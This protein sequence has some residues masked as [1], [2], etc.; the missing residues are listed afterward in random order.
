M[1][2]DLAKA[3]NAAIDAMRQTR[4]L[5]GIPDTHLLASAEKRLADAMDQAE[6]Q[7]IEPEV[8]RCDWCGKAR[9]PSAYV[10]DDKAHLM[11]V[12][13]WCRGVETRRNGTKKPLQGEKKCGTVFEL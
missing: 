3:I 1:S 5:Y 10:G 12:C 6:D 9:K 7:A 8:T 13:A 4:I 11:I 2:E